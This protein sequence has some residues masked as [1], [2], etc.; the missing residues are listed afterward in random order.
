[1]PRARKSTTAAWIA[2]VAALSLALPTGPSFAG[3]DAIRIA[4]I[5]DQ[6][7]PMS[8]YGGTG[9]VI[10]TKLAVEEFGGKVLGKPIQVIAA[11]HQ[12]K[13]DVASQLTNR[14]IDV[15]KVDAFVDGASSAAT[16]AMQN[17]TREKGRIFLITGGSSSDLTGKDCSPTS[18]HLVP[19]TYAYARGVGTAVTRDGGK[20]WFFLTADYAFGAA[21]ERDARAVIEPLGATVVG[22]ARHPLGTADF[23][24]FLLQAQASGSDVVAFATSGS[25]LVTALKQ[26]GEYQ[27]ASD[28]TRLAAFTLD[29]S[30]LQS[31]GLAAANGVQFVL[32]FYWDASDVTRT[33]TTRFRAA[34]GGLLPGRNHAMSYAGVLHYLKAVQATGTDDAKVV[35]DWM[36][37]TPMNDMIDQAVTIRQDGRVMT[38]LLLLQA[39]KPAASTGKDDLLTVVSRIAADDAFRP[40]A[41]GGCPFVR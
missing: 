15:E 3:P 23:S 25:D 11:D 34:S 1:M 37:R 38:P 39:K 19:D 27:L 35:S 22:G 29:V 9:S 13:P 18:F 6:S 32:P 5:N 8:G 7:G 40:L 20:R 31:L 4:V 26:S 36:H 14:Y 21:L 30:D 41:A 10:A 12:N 33:W 28:R 2:I 17:I 24:S 16:L